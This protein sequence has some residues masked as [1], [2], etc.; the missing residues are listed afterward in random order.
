MEWDAVG[1]I[2]QAVSALALVFVLTQIRHAREEMRRSVSQ[3]RAEGVGSLSMLQAQ[4]P[5]LNELL[6]RTETA[7]GGSLG[8]YPSSLVE[9]TK[10]TNEEAMQVLWFHWAWWMYQAQVIRRG[11][12]DFNH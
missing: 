10:I 1:A 3:G 5:R 2:G 12:G 9:K 4:D 6:N 11:D 7:L 8:P